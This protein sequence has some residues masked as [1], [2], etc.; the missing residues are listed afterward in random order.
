MTSTKWRDDFTEVVKERSVGYVPNG[1]GGWSMLMPFENVHGNGGLLTT[2]GDLLKFTHNLETG[3]V[4]CPRF[5]EEMHRRGV[6]DD[7]REIAYA[8]G[9]FVGEYKGVRE[10]QHAGGTAAYKG[11]LTR[12]PDHGLAI[13]VMCNAGN[14]NAGALAHGVADV[15]LA[16]ALTEP[17]PI[18][19]PA[20]ALE[21]FAGVYRHPDLNSLVEFV[22]DEGKLFMGGVFPGERLELLPVSEIR[23]ENPAGISIVFETNG[24]GRPRPVIEAVVSRPVRLEPAERHVSTTAELVECVGEYTSHEAEVT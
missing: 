15:F 22:V 24:S 17:A 1:D 13:S 20:E 11:Y 12:Y 2:V 6:L 21:R 10:V 9:V 5:I 7:G 19:L 8:G 14:A 3:A 23:F 4:G 16:G 18:E